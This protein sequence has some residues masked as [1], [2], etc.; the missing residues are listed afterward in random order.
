MARQRRLNPIWLSKGGNRVPDNRS[1]FFTF[2]VLCCL[3]IAYKSKSLFPVEAPGW[4][5]KEAQKKL[6]EIEN[7]IKIS[8]FEFFRKEKIILNL[9][10]LQDIYV[11]TFRVHFA[12]PIKNDNFCGQICKESGLPSLKLIKTPKNC[13]SNDRENHEEYKYTSRTL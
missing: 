4:I 8:F 6:N 11:R 3:L 10:S 5:F 12:A 9:Q 1:A 7:K 2:R 13:S